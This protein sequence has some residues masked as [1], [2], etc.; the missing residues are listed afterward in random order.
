MNRTVI[1]GS[2]ALSV[3]SLAIVSES[4]A[5]AQTEA[6]VA[7]AD[8][9]VVTGVRL[10]NQRAMEQKR[11]AERIVDVI[12]ADDVGSLPDYSVAEALT[13]IA[14]V[15]VEGRNGDSEF[16]VVRG[17]R[18]DFN[19]LSIDGGIVPSTRN[20]GR[21]TQTSVIPSYVIK[22]TDVVKSF[23][24]DLDGNAIGGH[25]NVTTRSAFD[26][27]ETYFAARGAL[28]YFENNDGPV[29]LDQSA[30]ADFAYTQQFGSQDQFGLVLSASYLMQDYYTFLPGGNWTENQFQNADG[31]LVKLVEDAEAGA[32]RVP[33]GNQFYQYKNTIERLG[34]LAKFEWA[35]RENMYLALTAYHF[36]EDDSEDRWATSVYHDF[37][38]LDEV[39]AT[40]G[41]VTQG[42]LYQAYFDQGDTNTL[43]SVSL[44][45]HWAPDNIGEFDLMVVKAH[46]KRENP[47]KEYRFYATQNDLAF[48]YDTTGQ[49]TVVKFD[50]PDAFT[51]AGRSFGFN[52]HRNR[53]DVNEQ[54]SFQARFDFS[55]H[56]DQPGF[57]FKTGLSYRTDTRTQDQPFEHEYRLKRGAPSFTT[58]PFLSGYS[59]RSQ[60]DLYSGLA[61]SYLDPNS[62]FE[63]F[64][65]NQDDFEDRKDQSVE[66]L[67]SQYEIREDIS[68]GYVMGRYETDSL[69]LSAGV[70]YEETELES[71]GYRKVDGDYVWVI[72]AASY[73]KWLPSAHAIWDLNENFRLRA[74]YSRSL[75]RA[76]YGDLD[77]LGSQTQDDAQ[78]TISISSGNPRL[79]PRISD[80]FDISAEYYFPT[81][82]GMV[83]VGLFHKDIANEIFSRKTQSER[84]IGGVTYTVTQTRPAN[85]NSAEVKG[86][87][88][89][90]F[91][92]SFD[93]INPVLEDVGMH[94]NYAHI[95]SQFDIE[96]N[97][98]SLRTLYGLNRQ[99]RN[100]LNA[101]VFWTPG[102]FEFKAAYRYTDKNLISTNASSPTY[103]EFIGERESVDVQARYRLGA[104]WKV[105]LDLRNVTND[106]TPRD[107]SYGVTTWSRNYGRSAWLGMTYKY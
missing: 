53:L 43:N 70:R 21:A 26:Q 29:D 72:E 39:N 68:A 79:L 91:L 38:H 64:K 88:L 12:T 69:I 2:V 92:N 73:G 76:E 104:Q 57:G 36:E 47:F 20:G 55:R 94:L 61:V 82:D 50:N 52:N 16:I 71:A 90:L 84:E 83:S 93:F 102:D 5:Q 62:F 74:A 80:N 59:A 37:K 30:R 100:I 23:S 7:P 51:N 77:V 45:G 19:Y 35:P 85:A 25:V 4:Q 24:A 46:G 98:D 95:E 42:K 28:G 89:G 17:L 67:S 34:G 81:I 101:S 58:E 1:M 78:Q 105:F 96:M 65:N 54:D 27:D 66:S 63:Y 107:L 32:I 106:G 48:S 11:N 13:R 6:N 103:D 56:M 22:S 14:G 18:S 60:P 10:Q 15:S 9:I 31:S 99:P 33:A 97:D 75:G 3:L 8:T 41:H 40:S 86:I 49:Y 87:E 44:T